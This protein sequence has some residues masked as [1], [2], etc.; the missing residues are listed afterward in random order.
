MV[1]IMWSIRVLIHFDMDVLDPAEII[2]AVGVV[3]DGMKLA[4]VV[5]V[6]NDIAKK[7]EIVGLTVAEPMPRI[8]IRIKEM[9]NQLPLLK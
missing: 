8:A 2:A 3:P 6:I 4:E 9:L 7:K 1:K 5:R